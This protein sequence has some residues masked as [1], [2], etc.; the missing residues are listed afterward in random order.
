MPVEKAFCGRFV[1]TESDITTLNF[2]IIMVYIEKY[3]ENYRKIDI[4]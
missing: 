4:L 2:K 1:C 3:V